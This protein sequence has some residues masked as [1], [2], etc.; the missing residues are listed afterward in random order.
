MAQ[1]A[2][3]LVT[4][5]G[6]L[7]GHWLALPPLQPPRWWLPQCPRAAACA[8][9]K[10]Y[11]PITSK[12]RAAWLTARLAAR[13][14]GS[15]LLAHGQAPPDAVQDLVKPRLPTGGAMA[16]MRCAHDDRFVVLMMD[17]AGRP[18][19]V[20][21]VN[22]SGTGGRSLHREANAIAAYGRWL[23]P[24]LTAPRV[25]AN[26]PGLLVLD[27]VDWRMQWRPWRLTTDVAASL[28]AFHRRGRSRDGSGLAHGDCTPWNLLR[29]EAGWVL[30]DWEC[31]RP[32]APA[33]FDVLHFL[34]QSSTNLGKP[35]R[36]AVVHGVTTGRGW[37]GR[38]V[39]AY[40]DAAGLDSA[41]AVEHLRAYLGARAKEGP[42]EGP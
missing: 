41:G 23:A 25:L 21:K 34:V 29:H 3:A 9:V 42:Q 33:Y 20:A 5:A 16:V 2:T 11:H 36:S 6:G 8:G 7:I 17:R 38:V 40:A 22:L 37:V 24:P 18:S 35:S 10:V 30:L 39:W 12:G 1:Q 13:L 28:G 4:G 14:G 15:R 27:A 26:E 32:D 19:E 31:A